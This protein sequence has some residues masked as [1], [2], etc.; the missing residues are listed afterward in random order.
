MALWKKK[1]NSEYH[2]EMLKKWTPSFMLKIGV[3]LNIAFC[4]LLSLL[5]F[6]LPLTVT[7]I[8]LNAMLLVPRVDTKKYHAYW[9]FIPVVLTLLIV[10]IIWF[11]VFFTVTSLEGLL[12]SF[13]DFID[14]YILF[15]TK[16]QSADVNI[17]WWLWIFEAI[18]L[19]TGTSGSLF[20]VFGWYWGKEIGRVEVRNK[21]GKEYKSTNKNE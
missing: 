12:N 18:L 17:T 14:T 6:T 11:I 21:P 9:K 19:A 7:A 15:W 10:G 3:A 4:S 5:V 13:V 2:T 1:E 8:I 16:K 20:I